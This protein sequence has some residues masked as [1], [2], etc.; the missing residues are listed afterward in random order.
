MIL[1]FQHFQRM[2]LYK[3]STIGNEYYNE[4][5]TSAI[6]VLSWKIFIMKL[7]GFLEASWKTCRMHKQKGNPYLLTMCLHPPHAVQDCSTHPET[8]SHSCVYIWA[9]AREHLSACS[10]G[11]QSDALLMELQVLLSSSGYVQL[12]IHLLLGLTSPFSAPH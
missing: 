2:Y 5:F 7:K 10:Q 6:S 1:S 4:C 3:V 11:T 12:P 8:Y 9:P